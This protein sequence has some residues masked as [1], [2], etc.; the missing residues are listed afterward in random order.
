[1]SSPVAVGSVR[2]KI[3]FN[4]LLNLVWSTETIDLS[5]Y[6]KPLQSWSLQQTEGSFEG[7]VSPWI[8]EAAPCS[9]VLAS[10]HGFWQ[11]ATQSHNTLWGRGTLD[12]A[13][14]SICAETI[15]STCHKGYENET[16]KGPKSLPLACAMARLGMICRRTKASVMGETGLSIPTSDHFCGPATPEPLDKRN[17]SRISIGVPKMDRQIQGLLHPT[18]CGMR[19]DAAPLQNLRLRAVL[20]LNAAWSSQIKL[21]SAKIPPV[22][23]WMETVNLQSC[24]N[25]CWATNDK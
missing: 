4:G 19:R 12:I 25:Q 22:R 9:S 5:V 18:S 14:S 21:C 23:F 6:A 15:S 17:T 10:N 13:F 2:A 16:W 3:G 11:S 1:M 20:S 7:L 24:Q 8:Q